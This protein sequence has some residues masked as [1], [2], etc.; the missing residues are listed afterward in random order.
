M[1][2]RRKQIYAAVWALLL[3]I[4]V[5]RNAPVLITH[6]LHEK[7]IP[8]KPNASMDHFL[9][10]LLLVREPTTRLDEIFSRLP[11]GSPILFVS[12][13]NNDRWDFVYSAVC[14]LTW[15]RKIDKVELQPNERFSADMFPGTSVLFCGT[16]AT[17]TDA[18]SRES[19]GPNLTL[20]APR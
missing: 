10:A 5:V 17:N 19:I 13:R 9:E 20:I 1:R 3:S 7:I 11:A 4:F 15:P 16:P 2:F 8:A 6:L 14:Y 12:A 18:R